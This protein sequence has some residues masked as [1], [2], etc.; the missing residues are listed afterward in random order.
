MSV[1]VFRALFQQKKK[2]VRQATPIYVSDMW[3]GIDWYRYFTLYEG[4]QASMRRVADLV[5]VDE[6]FLSRAVRGRILVSQII[7]EPLF[8]ESHDSRTPI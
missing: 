3:S 1:H 5:G 2:S 4:L 6:R 7:V 8:N